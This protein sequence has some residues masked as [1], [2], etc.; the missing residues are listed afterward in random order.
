MNGETKKETDNH[1][2]ERKGQSDPA[3]D[4]EKGSSDQNRKAQEMNDSAKREF[5]F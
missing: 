3:P 2:V 5:E 1:D 4:H